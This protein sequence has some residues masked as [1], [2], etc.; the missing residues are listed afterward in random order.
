MIYQVQWAYASNPRIYADF[1]SDDAHDEDSPYHIDEHD[2]NGDIESG[3][4][5]LFKMLCKQH[6]FGWPSVFNEPKSVRFSAHALAYLLTASS[7]TDVSWRESLHQHELELDEKRLLNDQCRALRSHVRCLQQIE[8]MDTMLQPVFQ[9]STELNKLI[10]PLL[11]ADQW[12]KL[13]DRLVRPDVNLNDT[14]SPTRWSSTMTLTAVQLDWIKMFRPGS[15]EDRV[16][17]DPTYSSYLMF[18]VLRRSLFYRAFDVPSQEIRADFLELMAY[19]INLPEPY[20]FWKWWTETLLKLFPP[21]PTPASFISEFAAR[22]LDI[23]FEDTNQGSLYV[24]TMISR[25]KMF[26]AFRYMITKYIEDDHDLHFWVEKIHNVMTRASNLNIG[27]TLNLNLVRHLDKTYIHWLNYIGQMRQAAN[28]RRNNRPHINEIVLCQLAAQHSSLLSEVDSRALIYFISTLTPC[29]NVTVNTPEFRVFETQ[30]NRMHG[31][32][33]THAQ[34][35]GQLYQ[36]GTPIIFVIF[37][38]DFTSSLL[39]IHI[40]SIAIGKNHC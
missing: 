14:H 16:Y 6:P 30:L 34:A 32:F 22:Q 11:D 20:W 35:Y 7:V 17:R 40:L 1:D 10:S 8:T 12:A 25:G 23:Y 27:A 26:D 2:D 33:L 37:F 19:Y 13:L 29:K 36:N 38:I 18:E 39:Y 5:T 4:P 15:S 28:N 21:A 31:A 9:S 24:A 3:P